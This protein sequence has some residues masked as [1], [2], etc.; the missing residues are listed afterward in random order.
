MIGSMHTKKNFTEAA[1]LEL[2]EKVNFSL[3]C[4]QYA[5][6]VFFDIE[7]A[8]DKPIFANVEQ[9]L[10]ERGIITTSVEWI[11]LS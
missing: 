11:I 2:T 10:I 1:L 6:A 8:F 3:D 7:G 4:G 9:A 5:L